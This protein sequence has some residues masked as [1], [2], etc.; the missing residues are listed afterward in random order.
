MK[1]L[2]DKA[3]FGAAPSRQEDYIREGLLT[4]LCSVLRIR[5]K[6]QIFVGDP[7]DKPGFV[8]RLRAKAN[9]N[10]FG[11]ETL[12]KKRDDWDIEAVGWYWWQRVSPHDRLRPGSPGWGA[13]VRVQSAAEDVTNKRCALEAGKRGRGQS[14]VKTRVF[15]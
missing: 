4:W 12:E 13:E 15:S 11:H 1:T 7:A 10:E 9:V 6:T 2:T 14:A 8:L 3:L 5:G